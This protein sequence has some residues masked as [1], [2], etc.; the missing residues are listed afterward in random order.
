MSDEQLECMQCG[1]YATE[2]V[3]KRPDEQFVQLAAIAEN[4]TRTVFGLTNAGNIYIGDFNSGR[5]TWSK[6]QLPWD[7]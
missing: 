6:G 5:L 4:R 3:C 7:K 2:C 1:E